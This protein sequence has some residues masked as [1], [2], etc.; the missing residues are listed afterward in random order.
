MA[1]PPEKPAPGDSESGSDFDRL[2]HFLKD[3]P[4]ALR[5]LAAWL[6]GAEARAFDR[7]RVALNHV[8]MVGSND[9]P[10]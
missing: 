3:K 5:L 2:M 1:N 9:R 6:D 7:I 10:N 8:D 4:L